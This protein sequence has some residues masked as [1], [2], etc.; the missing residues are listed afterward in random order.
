[1]PEWLQKA[2]LSVLTVVVILAGLAWNQT[3]IAE[4]RRFVPQ[5]DI[6]DLSPRKVMF[7]PGDDTLLLVVNFGGRIDVFDIRSPREPVKITEIDAGAENASFSPRE[8]QR[9]KIRIVSAG[10]DGTVR[11]WTLDGKPAAEPFKGHERPVLSVAFSPDGTRIVSAGQDGTVRLWNVTS[12]SQT[13]IS[14]CSRPRGLGFVGKKLLWIDCS[15]RIRIQ[16]ISFRA[17]GEL[18]LSA[19]GLVAAV[20]DEGVYVPNDRLQPFRA[21]TADNEIMW[22]R[23]AVTELPIERV[24]QVLL[25]DWTMQ[26]RVIERLQQ[27]RKFASDTYAAQH[28]WWQATFWPALGWLLVV[29]VA[30]VV[31][32]FAPHRLASWAMPA[33]GSPGLPPWKWLAGALLLFGYLG[34]T[35]RPLK[36]WL[37]RH[38]KMLLEQAFTGRAP[39][40]ERE[41]FCNLSYGPEIARIADAVDAGKGVRVWISGVGGSGKSAVAYHMARVAMVGKRSAP[42]PVLVDEDWTGALVDHVGRQLTLGGRRPTAKMVEVLGARGSLCLLVD[43]LSERGMADAAEQLVDVIGKGA[44]RSVIVTS[45]QACPAGAVWQGFQT[46]VARPLTEDDVDPYVATYAPEA[47]RAQVRERITPLVAGRRD[48]SPL[49]LRFAIAQAVNGEVTST[50]T[51]DLVF[52]YVEALRSGRVDLSADDMMRAAAIDATEAERESLAPRELEQAYLR[53]VLVQEADRL[54]FMN[55]SSMA[56]VEPARVIELLIQCGLMNRNKINRRLQFAYDP[57]AEHL[58][59]WR[60]AQQAAAGAVAPLQARILQSPNTGIARAMAEIETTYAV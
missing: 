36:A 27:A 52:Q 5:L 2:A 9:D 44:F 23:H 25:D 49:F 17:R 29:I 42:L 56:P 4:T 59:A 28:W 21:V 22:Q 6:T 46:V 10:D 34:T 45:R 26:E 48:I 53:G 1:M 32:V 16:S 3:A 30:I 37:R 40:T 33:T 7:A 35:R 31:W 51:L 8:T 19:E 43:Q 38:R 55:A 15:D 54:A 14:S 11:L 57:V 12:R 60:T 18:F 39:V 41:K 47:E 58:A 24:R 20:F 13:P 50:N